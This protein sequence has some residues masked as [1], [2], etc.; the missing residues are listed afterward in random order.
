MRKL[1]K[2]FLETVRNLHLNMQKEAYEVQQTCYLLNWLNNNIKEPFFNDYESRIINQIKG[3][4]T[5]FLRDSEILLGK[6]P[7]S[8]PK[9]KIMERH[10]V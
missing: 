5:L 9:K 1:E 4:T 8:K 10:E 3:C 7:F 2:S 6:P